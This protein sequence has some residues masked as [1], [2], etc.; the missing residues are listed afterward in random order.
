MRNPSPARID[1]ESIKAA[2][3]RGYSKGYA[4]G[5]KRGSLEAEAEAKRQVIRK[6]QQEFLDRA[7]LA[8]LPAAIDAHGWQCGGKEISSIPGRVQLAADF[9]LEALHRRPQA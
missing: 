6:E 3:Q 4:A 1:A 7:F 9:A 8:A 5:R 2:E